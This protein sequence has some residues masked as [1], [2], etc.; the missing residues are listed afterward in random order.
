MFTL[1]QYLLE[2]WTTESAPASDTTFQIGYYADGKKK[3][4]ISSE[5]QLAEALS[6]AKNGIVTLL[7][8]DPSRVPPGKKRKAKPNCNIALSESEEYGDEKRESSYDACLLRLRK[9]HKLPEFKL[10]CWARMMAPIC[11]PILQQLKDF[12][13]L[14]DDGVLDENE[15]ASKKDKLLTELSSL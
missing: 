14:K 6:L 3:Y 12:K 8:K 15:F 11:S 1:K 13:S 9:Q 5:I 7:V 2:N 4:S 10:R